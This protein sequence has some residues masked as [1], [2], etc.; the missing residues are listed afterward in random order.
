MSQIGNVGQQLAT[1]RSQSGTSAKAFVTTDMRSRSLPR[2]GS[3]SLQ[4]SVLP[5]GG[6]R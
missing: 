3:G 4:P 2:G 6:V 5:E 1:V